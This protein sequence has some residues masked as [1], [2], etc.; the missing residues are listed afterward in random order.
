MNRMTPTVIAT[1]LLATTFVVSAQSAPATPADAPAQTD[2]QLAA[3]ADLGQA[4]ATASNAPGDRIAEQTPSNCLRYTGSRIRTAD[5]KTGK[6]ACGG[7]GRAYGRDDI[8]RTGRVDLAD[9][10]RHLDPSIR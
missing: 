1:C 6:A 9:A 10:L 8:D 7:P 4:D 2:M 3:Q 5:R